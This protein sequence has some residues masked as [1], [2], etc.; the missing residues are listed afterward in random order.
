MY[1]NAHVPIFNLVRF[2][3]R[4]VVG[5]G[6][7]FV[8][9]ANIPSSME[10]ASQTSSIHF[11]C[12]FWN[13]HWHS[14]AYSDCI[15]SIASCGSIYGQHRGVTNAILDSTL[16]PSLL[17]MTKPTFDLIVVGAGGGPDECDISAYVPLQS[18]A[19]II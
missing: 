17:P 14:G 12:R 15:S 8:W 10:K 11:P 6:A 5:H 2:V 9:N 4:V 19:R 18:R 7:V 13:G 16:F 3:P 1:W